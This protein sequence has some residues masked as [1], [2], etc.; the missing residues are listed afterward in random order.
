MGDRVTLWRNDMVGGKG[1]A[2][3]GVGN[4]RVFSCIKL[5]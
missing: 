4:G 5:C 3:G 2:G 1:I